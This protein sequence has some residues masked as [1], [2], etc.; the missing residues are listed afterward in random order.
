MINIEHGRLR[1]FEED[2][3]LR[4][5]LL[6]QKE[7]GLDDI[8]L[9]ALCVLKIGVRK[10][11]KIV[12]RKSVYLLKQGIY[13]FKRSG[14]LRL[15]HALIEQ[16][17]H[18]KTDAAHLVHVRG[19]YAFF[20]G[21]DEIF[22]KRLLTRAVE[23]FVIRHHKVGITRNAQV[24]AGYALAFK[25]I[26]LFENDLGI[27]DAAIS[28]HGIGCWIHYARRNLVKGKFFVAHTHGMSGVCA[29][30]IAAHDVKI[31]CNEIGYL[32]FAFVAPLGTNKN[33]SGH[34]I[35]LLSAI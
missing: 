2:L 25:G 23:I 19:A 33:C 1:A 10:L 11:I 34:R 5:K 31:A 8:G 13:G 32:T 14:K 18:A 4:I 22:A 15:E 24:L 12:G 26:N 9:E 30:R 21:A 27:Y 28:N 17:L 29:S 35:P 3:L 6:V 7:R 20:G 16:I